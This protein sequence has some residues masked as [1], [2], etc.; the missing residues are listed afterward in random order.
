MPVLVPTCARMIGNEPVPQWLN[1]FMLLWFPWKRMISVC[2]FGFLTLWGIWSVKQWFKIRCSHYQ[3]ERELLQRL[4]VHVQLQLSSTEDITF[5]CLCSPGRS[6]FHTA[7]LSTQVLYGP[8][9]WDKDWNISCSANKVFLDCYGEVICI[10]SHHLHRG[11]SI[12]TPLY[13]HPVVLR[14]DFWE[15]AKLSWKLF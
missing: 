3:R 13:L 12:R 11:K 6:G 2:G 9:G 5:K 10:F 7:L 15:P 8:R 1:T 14:D 4:A